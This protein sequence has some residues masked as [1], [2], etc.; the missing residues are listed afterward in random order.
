MTLAAFI[1]ILLL[2]LIG[3]ISPG[4]AFVMTVRTAAVEGFRPAFLASVGLGTGAVCWALAALLGLSLV[5]QVAPSALLIFK[6]AGAAFLLWIAW[7]TFRHADAPLPQ[8]DGDGPAPRTARSA[9]RLG[10]LTQLAN[11][12]IAVFFGAVF[13][14]MVPH[15][16]PI[17]AK[18]AILVMILLDEM[19][20]YA[21]VGRVFS[22]AHVRAV[23]GR[24][25]RWIDRAFGVL[26][27]TFGIRI[28]VT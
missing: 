17:W 23:Y 13:V 5:F 15:D 20:W 2:H 24:A 11:P 6:L 16:A 1:S 27:A 8:V 7:Q 3:A 18:A 10:L 25:K 12:K 4:P 19:L 26:I 21:F 14:G 22:L 28:A 9:F